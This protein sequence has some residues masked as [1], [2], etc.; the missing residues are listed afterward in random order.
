MRVSV[1]VCVSD[2]NQIV[3]PNESRVIV[4]LSFSLSVP[5]NL[6]HFAEMGNKQKLNKKEQKTK[7][8][9]LT[10]KKVIAKVCS[11]RR[12]KAKVRS[13]SLP[14][15]VSLCLSRSLSREIV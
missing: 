3:I 15:L 2:D 14:L 12:L 6:E 4:S 11:T 13:I 5:A 7:S 10:A 9:K 8:K 1:C